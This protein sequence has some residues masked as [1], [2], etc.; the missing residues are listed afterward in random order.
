L[1]QHEA[2]FAERLARCHVICACSSSLTAR[3]ASGAVSPQA[4]QTIVGAHRDH[5]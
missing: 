4:V 3:P 2:G 5:V 1:Q